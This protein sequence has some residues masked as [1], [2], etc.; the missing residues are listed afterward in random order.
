MKKQTSESYAH[1][2]TTPKHNKRYETDTNTD[3]IDYADHTTNTPDSKQGKATLGG[4]PVR[5]A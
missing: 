5:V 3:S 2:A 4:Y 1:N